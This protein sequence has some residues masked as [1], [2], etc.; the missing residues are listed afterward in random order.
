MLRVICILKFVSF[1]VLFKLLTFNNITQL[2][3]LYRFG[4]TVDIL[5]MIQIFLLGE[6]ENANK[7]VRCEMVMVLEFYWL[8]L[9]MR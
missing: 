3:I 1:L 5:T 9:G 4:T 2:T 6:N 7:L 8:E